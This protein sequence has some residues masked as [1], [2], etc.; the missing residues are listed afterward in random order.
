MRRSRALVMLG[1]GMVGKTALCLR[2]ACDR[3][4]D[5]YEPTYE[6]SVTKQLLHRAHEVEVRIKD[7]QGLTSSDTFR[8]EYGI[9]YHGY[10][11]VY[12]VASA[13]SL[14][15]VTD[16]NDR[17]CKLIGT[18]QVPRVLV[19]NKSDIG[20][21]E[22]DGGGG[23]G[24]TAGGAGAAGGG[25]GGVESVREGK[26]GS[27][28]QVSF[29]TGAALAAAWGIPFIECS[30]RSDVNVDRVFT[31]LLDEVERISCSED[32]KSALASLPSSLLQSIGAS[33]ACACCLPDIDSLQEGNRWER[34][35][36]ALISAT[37]IVAVACLAAATCSGITAESTAQQ[38][39]SYLL[40][41]FAFLL[42]LAATIGLF[43]IRQAAVEYLRTF[44]V[45]CALLAVGE[46]L[47]YVLLVLCK[48]SEGLKQEVEGDTTVWLGVA[49]G[50][51]VVLECISA[52]VVWCYANLLQQSAQSPY[53]AGTYQAMY[54]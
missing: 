3:F 12:S 10:A 46:V 8:N 37:L 35:V 18:T 38:L 29:E 22:K 45:A 17:L 42:T 20:S 44:S 15:V 25:G 6:N 53:T 49:V 30:A 33:L 51:V 34:T 7:T 54:D 4:D 24:G 32:G 13:A 21:G 26:D 36:A 41:S 1:A 52:G 16:I 28:R 47:C 48:L 43:G 39:L 23:G 5:T 27:S 14:Q 19:G 40:F 31:T 2:F 50:A 9:G 11:L